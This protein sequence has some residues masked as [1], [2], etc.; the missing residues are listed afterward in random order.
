MPQVYIYCPVNGYM[1]NSKTYLCATVIV[2]CVVG[3]SY[4][5]WS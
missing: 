5:M 1:C 4:N 2:R 3:H